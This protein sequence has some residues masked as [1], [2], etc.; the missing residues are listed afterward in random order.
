MVLDDAQAPELV[1][2]DKTTRGFITWWRDLPQVRAKTSP[3]ARGT[4]LLASC[5]LCRFARALQLLS[6]LPSW[7]A[8]HSCIMSLFLSCRRMETWFASSTVRCGEPT[9]FHTA[10]PRD[11]ELAAPTVIPFFRIA[12]LPLFAPPF[13]LL[14]PRLARHLLFPARPAATPPP[15]PLL[16]Q[17][18]W[19]VHGDSA[20]MIARRY[21]RTTAVVKYLGGGGGPDGG[22]LPGVTLNRALF[23]SVLRELL[24][25]RSDCSVEVYEGFGATW[26]LARRVC[27]R[28]GSAAV[29]RPNGRLQRPA[30][31]AA[32]LLCSTTPPHASLSNRCPE[33]VCVVNICCR[34]R[35]CMATSTP[36]SATYVH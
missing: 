5:Y 31:T 13:R 6:P 18:F 35:Q 1:L 32:Q 20:L 29:A 33:P 23:E 14:L 17:G 28:I 36:Q 11:A 16:P 21:Y 9:A 15:L 22:G 30:L 25:E 3:S 7:C 26:K 27:S 34:T 24:L 2:D 4:A 10:R 12:F 19:S 8:G